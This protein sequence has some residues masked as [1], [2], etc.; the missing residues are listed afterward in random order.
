MVNS[1]QCQLWLVMRSTHSSVSYT[2]LVS[3]SVIVN[4]IGVN[5]IEPYGLLVSGSVIVNHINV[6]YSDPCGLLVSEPVFS[7]PHPC[8]V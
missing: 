8:Q 7:E 6:T 1:F 5:C 2:E 3:V 4:H